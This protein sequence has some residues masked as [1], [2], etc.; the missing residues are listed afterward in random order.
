MSRYVILDRDG[1]INVERDYLSDPDALELLPG[2]A[3]GL[4]YLRGLG[5]GLIVV[6]NQ[7]GVGRGY[8][9]RDR[10]EEIHARLQ[11]MLGE[12]G[13]TLD[14]IYFCPHTPAE[15]CSCRKPKT[16]LVER[17]VQDFH[18][19]PR[20][21]FVIGDQVRDMQLGR[22]LGATTLLVT[23]GYGLETC[24]DP[25]ARPDFL[26]GSLLE[27]AHVIERLLSEEQTGSLS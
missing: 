23:T 27:A 18:F 19:D 24:K 4:R 21:C 20:D 7:S 26:V 9:D 1:T 6:T 15:E 25:E 22:Q 14:G 12:Q 5:L 13:V 16:G 8:F 17:A 3:D 11:T 10:L 2:A